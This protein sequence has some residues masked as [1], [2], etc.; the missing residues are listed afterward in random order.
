[1]RTTEQIQKDIALNT[2]ISLKQVSNVLK[3]TSENCTVHFIARYRKEM[4]NNLNEDSIRL[5]ISENEKAIA[6]DKAKDS[7]LKSIE[8][9]GKLTNDLKNSII[10]AKTILELDD[11]YAPYKRKRKT[12]ADIA[13]ENGFEPVA[14]LIRLQK[15]IVISS[16]LSSKFSEDEIIQG[17]IDILA[18][19]IA[20]DVKLKD[21][22]RNYYSQ[23]AVISS[24]LKDESKFNDKQ[25]KEMYKFKIYYSF[26]SLI[27]KL[28]SYQILALNRA[29]SLGILK[30]NLL[31]EDSFYLT[32]CSKLKTKSGHHPEFDKAIKSGYDKLFSSVENELRSSLTE[33]AELKAISLFQENLTKLLML[34]PHNDKTILAI[35]PGFRTGCKICVLVD[36]MPI[37]FSKIYLDKQND[38]ISILNSLFN[39]YSID[40]I[41]IGN[42]TAS[43][44]SFEL[45]STN[46][47]S[48][49]DKII[50]V[51]ESGAS[52]YSTSDIGKDEFPSLDATDRGTISIG[53]RYID[54][55][56]ELVK[57]PVTSIGVG[58]YQHDIN[59]KV[60]EKKL[61]ETVEDVV[62]L[63][64]INV[65]TASPYLLSYVSGINKKTAQKIFSNRPYVSRVALKKVLS[66]KVYEQCIGFLRVPIS[67]EILDNTAIHP[68]QYPLAKFII[69]KI[70]ESNIYLSY[71]SDLVKLYPLVALETVNDIINNYNLLGKELRQYEGNVNKTK[72]IKIEDLKVD[73]ILDGI[74][75][76]I[77]QFGVFVD[78]GLKNDGFV[79]ISNIANQFVK[80]PS[81]FVTIGE[82]IKVKV[83]EIDLDKNRIALSIKGV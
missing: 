56:S 51:N 39:K 45:I 33:S 40:V 77:T 55:L 18:Q 52:V 67:N 80:N 62:N 12:K 79:H 1:M 13:R 66:A 28:K 68:E 53:R 10:N 38:T 59:Q 50:I 42:G 46:F 22:V 29:E 71:K 60:L 83:I 37:E 26:T 82:S 65:N 48:Y 31:K 81:D 14:T 36:G 54:S 41:V 49:S 3:L 43:D 69:S 23:N 64:G 58:M 34:K 9:Q 61:S 15:P 35:D 19:D 20:D 78:I 74:V 8:E 70:N 4:T 16:E 7:A 47:V 44:E 30:V 11:I 27:T 63:V 57:V 5:I 25:Q 6:L 32:F 2:K 75:R 72:V 76:N 17:A 21:M 24:S 73:D